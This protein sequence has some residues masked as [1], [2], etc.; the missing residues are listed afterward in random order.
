[1]LAIVKPADKYLINIFS[2]CLFKLYKNNYKIFDCIEDLKKELMSEDNA[3]TLVV[4]K[5]IEGTSFSSS[6][7]HPRGYSIHINSIDN[8]GNTIP[9]GF[10]SPMFMG[11]EKGITPTTHEETPK[12]IRP[13]ELREENWGDD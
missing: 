6:W 10:L 11:E 2:G 8:N 4:A 1:M 9:K 7:R 3:I 13:G 12:Y 5:D